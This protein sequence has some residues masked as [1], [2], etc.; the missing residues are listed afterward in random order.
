[1]SEQ[2]L[3]VFL[4][5]SLLPLPKHLDLWFEDGWSWSSGRPDIRE[6]PF[7]RGGA[8]GSGCQPKIIAKLMNV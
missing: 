4:F 5:E 2:I 1:M 6:A 8:W 3:C 7:E